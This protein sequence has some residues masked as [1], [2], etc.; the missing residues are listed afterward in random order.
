MDAEERVG[1]SGCLFNFVLGKLASAPSSEHPIAIVRH[2]VSFSA[3]SKPGEI[4]LA[5]ANGQKLCI[6]A[7]VG[8]AG[9]PRCQH[10]QTRWNQ[11][12]RNLIQFALGYFA[13]AH[14]D[15]YPVVFLVRH[16]F[17]LSV[18]GLHPIRWV[19]RTRLQRS[20]YSSVVKS[21]PLA[22]C[23]RITLRIDG[24]AAPVTPSISFWVN[25]RAPLRMS[26]RLSLF[27]MSFLLF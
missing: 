1:C 9:R 3:F 15:E 21:D 25:R 5:K 16:T 13:G 12:A 18:P 22:L 2:V 4:N 20:C 19:W 27:D 11:T 10:G 8:I 6:S 14:A 23:V 24:K 7:M 17:L 26:T